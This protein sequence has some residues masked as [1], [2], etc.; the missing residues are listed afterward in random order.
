M[1][2]MNLT[3]HSM[4]VEAANTMFPVEPVVLSARK[5]TF[6]QVYDEYRDFIWHSLRRLGVNDVA[7]DDAMQDAFVVVHRRLVEFQGR[8]TLKTWLFGIA[9]RVSKDYRRT[10]RRKGGLEPL[11]DSVADAAPGPLESATEAEG[12]RVAHTLLAQLDDDRRAVFILAEIE[13]MTRL[14]IAEAL[15]VN[16]NTVA[17]RLRAAHQDFERAIA[18]FHRKAL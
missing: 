15:G 13:Q 16:P 17:S 4:Q 3:G 10:E 1:T 6:E 11:P 5:W 9:L 2:K 7:L 8:S 12:L 14:E 18:R